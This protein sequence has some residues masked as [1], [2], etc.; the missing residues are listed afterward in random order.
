MTTIAVDDVLLCTYSS[1]MLITLC[2]THQTLTPKHIGTYIKG[3]RKIQTA[4][5]GSVPS[6]IEKLKDLP[7]V[8][9]YTAGAICSIAYGK[10]AAAVDGNVLR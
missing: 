2:F 10:P 7:G 5:G 1:V 6:D 8:G 3:A 4:Y 9:P